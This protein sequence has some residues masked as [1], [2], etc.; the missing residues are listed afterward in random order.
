MRTAAAFL[1]LAAC[2]PSAAQ[3]ALRDVDTHR[4]AAHQTLSL[5]GKN[6][7]RAGRLLQWVEDD[8]RGNA[9]VTFENA[10]YEGLVHRRTVFFAGFMT[11]GPYATTRFQVRPARC[12]RRA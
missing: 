5:D 11:T 9:S 4:T 1:F 8:G 3:L 10:A 12:G 6:S 2:M 7:A